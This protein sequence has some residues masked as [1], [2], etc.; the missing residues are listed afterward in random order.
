M[1]TSGAAANANAAY[2]GSGITRERVISIVM[3]LL[4]VRL[5]LWFGAPG[6]RPRAPNYWSPGFWYGVLGS[7]YRSGDSFVELTDGGHFDNL[8]VYELVRRRL[9]AVVVLDSEEDPDTSMFALASLCQRVMEDFGAIVE[10]GEKADKIAPAGDM[11]YP[12]KAAFT[13]KSFFVTKI[14]YPPVFV[15]GVQRK[16]AKTGY[17]VYIKS[18]MI[19]GLSFPARGYK[20]KNPDFPNQST[21]D[22]FFEPAQFEAYRE[23]GYSSAQ[24]FIENAAIDG[25]DKETLFKKIEAAA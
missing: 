2:L 23:L 1:A 11:G 4:N 10:I 17:L 16:P 9:D 3:M 6:T 19:R 15:N 14:A 24:A 21:M 13:E 12:K 22:Q 18:N 7:G 8:G 5:G 25:A 20:A